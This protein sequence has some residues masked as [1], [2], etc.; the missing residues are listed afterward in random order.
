MI[1]DQQNNALAVS[2]PIAQTVTDAEVQ[3]KSEFSLAKLT[4]NEIRL[5]C[6][7]RDAKLYSFTFHD[8]AD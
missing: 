4:G 3:W 2:E 6:E 8:T 1:L 5:R 7:L